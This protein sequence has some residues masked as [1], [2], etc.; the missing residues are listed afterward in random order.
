ML[1]LKLQYFG[2]LMWRTNSL[3]KTTM[4]G[5]IECIREGDDI[6]WDGWMASLMWWTWVWV[7]SGSWWWTGKPGVL[8]SMGLQRVG[9]DW[10]TELNWYIHHASPGFPGGSAAAAAA[11][12]LQSCPTL[13][14]PID[15]R[16]SLGFSCP[17]LWD[18]PGK[19]TGVGC[20]F[21]LQCMKVENESE[22]TQSFQT[23]SD[24]MDCSLPG[25]SVHG[26]LQ[27]RVV[28]WGAI[29]FSLVA[30]NLLE[31]QETWLQS[32]DREDPLEK[33][34][35]TYFSFLPEES[36]GQ[37]SMVGYSLWGHKESDTTEQLMLSL[38]IF[39]TLT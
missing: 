14:D 15:G 18:S 8:Q 24:P 27:A 13:F 21:L 31:M 17:C 3:E 39:T 38:F 1:K 7:G 4:L 33:V 29:A 20:R 36:H 16:D 25:S 22:V 9:H 34:M 37:R 10:V 2:H 12:S 23:V 6:G 35:A 32:L 5:K 30:L 26:I 19:N 11:K 28:E